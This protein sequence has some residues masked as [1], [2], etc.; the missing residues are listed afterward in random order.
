MAVQRT[1]EVGVRKVLG[2]TVPSIVGI[3]YEDFLVLL[4]I[5]GLISLPAVY[6]SMNSWLSAYAYR[7]DFPWLLTV[8]ALLIV[9]V[10]ALL[11]VGYQIYKVAVL[12]P[13]QTMRHE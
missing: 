12:N 5:A 4:G 1:A 9:V 3:F 7:I 11:T 10:V 13:A 6:Y 8:V 2:A